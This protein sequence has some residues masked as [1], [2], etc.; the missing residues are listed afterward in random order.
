MSGPTRN[1][2]RA[3]PVSKCQARADW[4]SRH[5]AQFDVKGTSTTGGR[6][7]AANCGCDSTERHGVVELDERRGEQGGATERSSQLRAGSRARAGEQGDPGT[8]WSSAEGATWDWETPWRGAGRS[9]GHRAGT[10]A[11]DRGRAE[12]AA[13]QRGG[14]HPR[15]AGWAPSTGSEPGASTRDQRQLEAVDTTCR[16]APASLKSQAGRV[17]TRELGG[18]EGAGD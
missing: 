11:R 1:A 15:R 16:G 5:G 6:T 2:S 17:A 4:R 14:P 9:A 12:R 13:W 8:M 3:D 7:L 10:R 18:E